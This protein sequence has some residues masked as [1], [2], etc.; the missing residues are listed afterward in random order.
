MR[1]SQV[2][3]LLTRIARRGRVLLLALMAIGLFLSVAHSENGLSADPSAASAE[4]VLSDLAPQTGPPVGALAA[5]SVTCPSQT[6]CHHGQPLVLFVSDTTDAMTRG[7]FRRLIP[8]ALRATGQ[9]L[10]LDLPPPIA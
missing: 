2:S 6:S 3:S 4:L 5:Q 9:R 1:N 8:A 10:S 7:D